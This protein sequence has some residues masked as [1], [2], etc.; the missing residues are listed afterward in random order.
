MMRNLNVSRLFVAAAAVAVAM[1]SCTKDETAA[2]STDDDS[3]DAFAND[4]YPTALYFTQINP[5]NTTSVEYFTNKFAEDFLLGDYVEAGEKSPETVN[6]PGFVQA[7]GKTYVSVA[8]TGVTGYSVASDDFETNM[9]ALLTNEGFGGE[10]WDYVSLNY[11]A[12][13]MSYE[14]DTSG[15]GYSSAGSYTSGIA[16]PLTP[17]KARVAVYG[18]AAPFDLMSATPSKVLTTELIGQAYGRYLG[19]PYNTMMTNSDESFVYVFSPGTTRKF[20]CVRTEN[21]SDGTEILQEYTS[22]TYSTAVERTVRKVANG[23]ATAGVIRINTTTDAIDTSFGTNGVV[24]LENEYFDGC[25]FSQV[26]HITGDKFLLRVMDE[27][28]TTAHGFYYSFHKSQPWDTRFYIFDA[29][30]VTMTEI[31]GLPVYA[32]LMAAS[33][34]IGEPLCTSDKVYIPYSLATGACVYYV[35]ITGSSYSGVKGASSDANYIYGMGK[36]N[37]ATYGDKIILAT[38]VTDGAFYYLDATVAE[39]ESS[40]EVL[41][42]QGDGVEVNNGQV[43]HFIE[44]KYLFTIYEAG[45]SDGVQ[46][47]GYTLKD[48]GELNPL[49]GTGYWST[50]GYHAEGNLGDYFTY[51][52]WATLSSDVTPR[53][54]PTQ[55]EIEE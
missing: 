34:T 7:N 31:S 13:Y 38:R 6:F 54:Y 24:E 9:Q 26:W 11:S 15:S 49:M 36:L 39:V 1:S 16:F 21:E 10:P 22:N 30:T 2:N 43:I 52:R 28:N 44:D 18:Q 3:Y 17:H 8:T 46:V 47:N 33:N 27:A 45:G 25:T 41:T 32:D 51:M 42:M 35:D 37:N 5:N 50:S 40:S 19:N 29:A 48:D 53:Q 4:F 14:G 55:A 23:G 20:D 12:A